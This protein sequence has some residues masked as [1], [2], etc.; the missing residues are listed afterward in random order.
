MTVETEKPV[1]SAQATGASE[2]P[3]ATPMLTH[4]AS[5][6]AF[7]AFLPMTLPLAIRPG[8][9]VNMMRK[10]AQFKCGIVSVIEDRTP[11]RGN[12][13]W[14]CRYT[15]PATGMEV[16]RR[17]AGLDLDDVEAIC[18][19]W[20]VDAY[21][22]KGYL[23]GRPQAPTLE[24]GLLEAIRLSRG[25]LR[26]KD[27]AKRE[28]KAF[29]AYMGQ[30]YPGA[31]TWGDVR[32][33]MIE[34][35]IRELEAKGLAF[36]TLRLRL[37]PVKSAW[38]RMHAD[39]PDLVK[40][41]ASIAT[42]K[43]SL[44]EIVCLEGAEVVALL[45]WLRVNRPALWPMAALQALCGL[46]M[47][48]AAA[49]RVQDVDMSARTVTIA[50]TGVHRP[51]TLSSHRTIPVCAEVLMALRET[52]TG[53][54]VRLVS[55][56]LFTDKNGSAW[57]ADALTHR[58]TFSLRRAAADLGNPRLATIP[59]RKLRASFAT[60]AGVFGV[61]D[62]LLKAYMG[63]SAGDMLGAHYRRI[64]PD[65]LRTVSECF[66]N[67]RTALKEATG[68]KESGNIPQKAIAEG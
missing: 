11:T 43:R 67:W 28:S 25:N 26:T 47:L 29:L 3:E 61:A 5:A 41:P 68:R 64:S 7:P 12:A 23:A 8:E 58:W 59:A 62:R 30:R 42:A 48:E 33:G 52:M 27:R 56:E 66:E 34:S 24:D 19:K 45:D 39:Y 50:D 10:L 38:R 6:T 40:V 14:R 55:G 21:Q 54:K 1:D 13:I 17:L 31:R 35:Y 9:G 36:D 51:K 32:P 16:K 46:R 60:M 53:Q 63:H 20:T 22:G 44:R 15:D 4:S 18:K 37:V 57:K 65:E 2:R 49:L